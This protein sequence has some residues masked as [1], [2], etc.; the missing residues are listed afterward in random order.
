MGVKIAAPVFIGADV[1][2]DALVREVGELLFF[3]RAGDWFRRPLLAQ[4]GFDLGSGSNQNDK[5][6]YS[7]YDNP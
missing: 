5:L 7:D 2:I 1:L 6:N 4:Q 3:E